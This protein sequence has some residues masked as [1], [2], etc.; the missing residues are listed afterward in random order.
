MKKLWTVSIATAA[1]L[2][3]AGTATAQQAGPRGDGGGGEFGQRGPAG[4][5]MF[6]LGGPELLRNPK[7]QQD[8]AL[9]DEQKKKIDELLPRPPRFPRG[10]GQAGP[11]PEGGPAGP[12][13]DNRGFGGGPTGTPPQGGP[14]FGPRL[15]MDR[16]Q[17]ESKIK[18]ILTDK[19]FRRYH[20]IELQASAP[21]CMLRPEVAEK[22]GLN[23]DQ[24]ESLQDVI[25]EGMPFPPRGGGFGGPGAGVPPPPGGFGGANGGPPPEGGPGGPPPGGFGGPPPGGPGGFRPPMM[26]P[27]KRAE[28]LKKALAVLTE[29]QRSTWKAMTGKWID[30]TPPKRGDD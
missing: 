12:P 22:L 13:P 3:V 6:A 15:R 8:L 21:M 23:N 27:A 11:P 2:A 14:G 17:I 7:V 9:T 30:L 25:R 28:T 24:R 1:L 5:R 26:D 19:Q 18:E 10:G 20:E 29:K 4:P 16:E